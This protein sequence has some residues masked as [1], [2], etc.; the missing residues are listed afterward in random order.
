M[1]K[2]QKKGRILRLK[3]GYNPNSSSVGSEIPI[4]LAF[5][6][7][8]GILTIMILQIVNLY[9]RHIRNNKKE[10]KPK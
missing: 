2:K 5:A 10:I 4:F 7:G 1:E 8:S 3:K 6:A 9:D